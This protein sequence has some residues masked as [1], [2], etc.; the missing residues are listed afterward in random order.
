MKRLL[1]FSGLVGVGILAYFVAK[2]YI[3]VEKLDTVKEKFPKV[4]LDSFKR[5][6]EQ[7]SEIEEKIASLATTISDTA[8]ELVE[9]GSE[10]AQEKKQQLLNMIEDAKKAIQEEREKLK[11]IRERLDS[12]DSEV[13]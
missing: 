2:D 10:Y 13:V 12:Q 9:K 4:D 7:K 3:D 5:L 1:L 6:V 11:D 8:K